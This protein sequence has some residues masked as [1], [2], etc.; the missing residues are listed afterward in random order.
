MS[1]YGIECMI[2]INTLA[3]RGEAKV[4]P[5]HTWTLFRKNDMLTASLTS[6]KR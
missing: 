3:P 5:R 2:I 6:S 1:S 4:Q